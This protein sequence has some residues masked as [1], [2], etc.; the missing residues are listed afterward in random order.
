MEKG[1]FTGTRDS[2]GHYEVPD[3]F[4]DAKFGIWAHWGPQSAI[5]DGD[6]YARNMYMQGSEQNLYHCKTYGHPSKFGYKDTIP[7][8]KAER[9]DPEHLID[10]YKKAGAKY[11]MSMGVHH[12][13][14]D[15]WNSTHQSW[16][17]AKMGPKID[18]VGMWARAARNAGLRFGVSEHLWVSYKW[19]SVSH[20]HDQTGPMAGVP[21][22][23]AN[24]ANENLYIDSDQIW[25]TMLDWSETGVP[26]WW[27]RQWYLRIKDLIDQHQPDMLYTDGPL[28]FEDYG[29]NAIARLYNLSAS[30]NGGK[31]E[32]VYTCKRVEDAQQGI[33]VLDVERGVIDEISPRPWQTDTCI[34]QWHYKRGQIYK[35]PKATIDILVDVVSRN[36]NLMLNFPLPASGALDPQELAILAEITRWMSINGEA[37]HGTRPWKIFGTASPAPAKEDRVAFNEEKRKDLSADDLRFTTK[38][39]VLYAFI[40]GWPERES[41][42]RPLATGTELRVGKIQHV[43]LLGLGGNLQWSQGDS[44]LR[45]TIP[46]QKPCDH[47]IVLKVTGATAG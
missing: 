25:P 27:K 21:Y 14:F 11:F 3:W 20:G 35:T 44:G 16:N 5:E 9:F 19:F 23:G 24:P 41:L 13:N 8:W 39:D 10:L 7:N 6:W 17:A 36:G 38:G 32:G 30:R 1:P 4:R 42:I 31:T 18:I 12:D 29:L 26:T 45:V 46:P 22:D 40:M 15:M 37:I 28:P 2:L 47:A 43:E 33:S 34:G